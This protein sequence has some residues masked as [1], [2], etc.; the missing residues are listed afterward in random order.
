MLHPSFFS[1]GVVSE[2]RSDILRRSAFC[3]EL[4]T[5][6]DSTWDSPYEH[7]GVECLV[8]SCKTS[9]SCSLQKPELSIEII[10]NSLAIA[11]RRP[12]HSSAVVYRPAVPFMRVSPY[13][14]TAYL[15]HNCGP[16][17]VVISED[18]MPRWWWWWSWSRE[19]TSNVDALTQIPASRINGPSG[20]A[21]ST[22]GSL[23][24]DCVVCTQ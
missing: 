16:R 5:S 17:R 21:V 7:T 4:Q 22:A 10:L 13:D 12:I 6:P 1:W 3:P 14:S 20:P 2:W 24:H 23:S 8:R 18:I 9:S 15:M 19:Q 11:Q